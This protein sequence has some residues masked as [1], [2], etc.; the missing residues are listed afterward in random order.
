[1]EGVLEV[2][3]K[4]GSY[5]FINQNVGIFSFFTVKRVSGNINGRTIT[6]PSYFSF[7]VLFYSYFMLYYI[8]G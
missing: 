4:G 6:M 1:M 3:G 5:I 2:G 8:P 7:A